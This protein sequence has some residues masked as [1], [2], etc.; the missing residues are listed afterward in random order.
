MG[1][2]EWGSRGRKGKKEGNGRA[3][4]REK[5][6]KRESKK[7]IGAQR[8][9]EGGRCWGGERRKIEGETNRERAVGGG[10]RI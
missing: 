1:D 2:R 9:M 4:E 6:G 10:A 8:E 5:T 7:V 3:R